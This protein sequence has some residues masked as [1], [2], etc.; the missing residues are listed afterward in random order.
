MFTH[1]PLGEGASH[2]GGGPRVAGV[3]APVVGLNG[4]IRVL[5]HKLQK[6]LV[7]GVTSFNLHRH[8]DEE[9]HEE[10][11]TTSQS[12]DL[13]DCQFHLVFGKFVDL[14]FVRE[15]AHNGRH[16]TAHH[17]QEVDQE[18]QVETLV[19]CTH[20]RPAPVLELKIKLRNALSIENRVCCNRS[21]LVH[22]QNI[23]SYQCMHWH[24]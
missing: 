13:L 17:D 16:C 21:A 6:Q 22:S 5:G 24:I 10:G 15:K 4:P 12:D 20:S 11:D 1:C 18:H 14:S 9:G 7:E 19:S 23:H 3:L 2:R 8:R